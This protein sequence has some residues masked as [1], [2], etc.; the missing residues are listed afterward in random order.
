MDW[1]GE[2]ERE[3]DGERAPPPILLGVHI[4]QSFGGWAEVNTGLTTDLAQ[5]VHDQL[6]A[7]SQKIQGRL[8]VPS[9]GPFQSPP[10]YH[11]WLF[12]VTTAH[13]GSGWHVVLAGG[14]LRPRVKLSASGKLFPDRKGIVILFCF[15]PAG[16]LWA[17]L[18]QEFWTLVKLCFQCKLRC[19]RHGLWLVKK[20]LTFRKLSFLMFFLV[21]GLSF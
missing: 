2:W 7:V 4:S 17:E 11:Q 9:P 14:K 19:D 13:L 10:R 5:R 15:F 21:R 8:F 18:F 1:N 12:A 6:L 20:C 3:R 16:S